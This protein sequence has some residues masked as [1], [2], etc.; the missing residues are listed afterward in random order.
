M[1]LSFQKN[2]KILKIINDNKLKSEIIKT[3]KDIA[4]VKTGI[5]IVG[6]DKKKN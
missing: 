1:P 5:D 2:I 3:G 6:T 4:K